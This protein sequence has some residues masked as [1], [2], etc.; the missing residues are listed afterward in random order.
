VGAS[1]NAQPADSLL[2]RIPTIATRIALWLALAGVVF[3]LQMLIG[4]ALRQHRRKSV[5]IS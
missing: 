1:I 5:P 3:V 2:Q 4:S